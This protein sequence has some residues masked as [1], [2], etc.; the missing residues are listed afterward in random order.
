MSFVVPES[1]RFV[2]PVAFFVVGWPHVYSGIHSEK[3]NSERV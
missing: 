2:L 1:N 3:E